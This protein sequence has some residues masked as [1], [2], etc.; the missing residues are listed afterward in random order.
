V[1]ASQAAASLDLVLLDVDNGPGYLVYDDNA[2]LYRT[3]FLKTCH[4]RTRP[5]GVVA[6]WSSAQ[7]AELVDVM[8]AVFGECEELTVPVL[9]G[10]RE[11]TYH[12]LTGRV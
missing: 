6:V 9:L 2:S 4:D 12:V 1:V 3:E 5:G 7:A 11:T 10:T 8:R